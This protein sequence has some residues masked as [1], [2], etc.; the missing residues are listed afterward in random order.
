MSPW[1]SPEEWA[2]LEAFLDLT[3]QDRERSNGAFWENTFA[4]DNNL[5]DTFIRH[6]WIGD[7]VLNLAL[8]DHIE[9]SRPPSF[10]W[11]GTFP[12]LQAQSGDVAYQVVMSWPAEIRELLRM[13]NTWANR[14]VPPRVWASY[15]EAII[16]LLFR[17]HGYVPAR[18]FAWKHWPT[19]S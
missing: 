8:A 2:T 19:P 11:G 10:Y 16:G 12:Q 18:D 5:S 17:E 15:G 3:V 6:A 1:L 7:R 4:N 14:G 9:A 13:G